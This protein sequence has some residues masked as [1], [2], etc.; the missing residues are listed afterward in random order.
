MNT[1]DKREHDEDSTTSVAHAA[2]IRADAPGRGTTPPEGHLLPG[3]EFSE[4]IRMSAP[5]RRSAS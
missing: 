5:G 3:V 1:H 4:R 2:Q